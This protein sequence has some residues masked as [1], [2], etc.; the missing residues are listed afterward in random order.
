M[1]EAQPLQRGHRVIGL[2]R[3]LFERCGGRTYVG[4]RCVTRLE[5]EASDPSKRGAFVLFGVAFSDQQAD[6]ESVIEA[7]RR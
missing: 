7:D 5:R 2:V 4:E 6:A 3:Q 1:G